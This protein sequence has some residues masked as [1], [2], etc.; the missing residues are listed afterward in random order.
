M[1]LMT[2]AFWLTLVGFLFLT[3]SCVVI[4]AREQA[5][6][7]LAVG[8]GV[9]ILSVCFEPVS[10]TFLKGQINLILMGLV[11]MDCLLPRTPWP[12]GIL[13]GL[14]AAIKLTP[15]VFVL[16]FL[17]R[18]QWR[19]VVATVVSFLAFEG[20]GW[21]LAPQDSKDYWLSV[22]W[23]PDR[24]GNAGYAGNQ[25]LRGAL[26]R[27]DLSVSVETLVWVT[28]SGLVLAAT[29]F[30]AA[31]S[32]RRG[33]DLA[34]LI[35]IATSC[36]VVSPVS[37]S[38]HWVWIVPAAMLAGRVLWRQGTFAQVGAWAALLPFVISPHWW[39]AQKQDHRLGWRWWQHPLGDSYLLVALGFLIT[40]VI[41]YVWTGRHPDEAQ[42]VDRAERGASPSG[43]RNPV[44]AQT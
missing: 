33:D 9:A 26:H 15:A 13:I 17:V 29:W 42:P 39:F 16:F 2:A 25:A 12:R 22:L 44:A 3:A 19:P 6:S 1:S 20:L 23:D 31:L 24:I 7:A 37:W 35:A 28:V 30:L 8:A 32:R 4:A 34:A 38:H 41:W 18:W 43:D 36:L 40:M 5:P 14:A 27:L 11:V 21:W 10:Q